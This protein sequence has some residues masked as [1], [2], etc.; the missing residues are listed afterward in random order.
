M[1]L[2]KCETDGKTGWRYGASGTCY[3]YTAGDATSEKA[4]RRLAVKQ[5]LAIGGGKPPADL[6]DRELAE[7]AE[8]TIPEDVEPCLM[9]SS[10]GFRGKGGPQSACHLHDGTPAGIKKAIARALKDV[11]T[12]NPPPKMADALETRDLHDVEI[13]ATGGPYFGQGSPPEGDN[14]DLDYLEQIARN[15]NELADQVQPFVKVGHNSAQRLLRNSGLFTDEQ[16]AAGHLENFRVRGTKLVC[17]IRDV[18]KKLADLV[19]KKAF[20]KRSVELA[21]VVRQSA[22]GGDKERKLVVSALALLGAKAPAVRTLDDIAA[23]Y[24]DDDG[25]LAETAALVYADQ[26]PDESIERTVAFAEGDV[27]WD[28]ENGANDWR[29]D[30]AAAINAGLNPP[31]NSIPNYRYYVCDIDQINKQ[32]LV[33]DYSTNSAWVVPFTIPP[34]TDDG[35]NDGDPVPAPFNDWVMA[36]Q[37]WVQSAPDGPGSGLSDNT[38]KGGILTAMSEHTDT[39]KP[40]WTDEQIA[41]F[42]TGFGIDE[43]DAAKRRE[44]VLAKFEE[45]AKAQTPPPPPEP[46]APQPPEPAAPAVALSE[47]ER[48]YADRL[49]KLEQDRAASEKGRIEA[50]LRTVIAQGKIDPSEQDHW[51]SLMEKD[52]D[53]TIEVLTRLPVRV[54]KLRAFGSDSN[55]SPAEQ[56]EESFYRAYAAATK[57]PV[58]AKEVQQ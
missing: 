14:F 11:G 31:G 4:A 40:E 8:V 45:R 27:I 28:S 3:T 34:D 30:L 43:Q 2:Q 32:A 20:R 53:N 54:D 24:Y 55:G 47:R 48:E 58:P 10:R 37:A 33:Q 25:N 50:N 21:R 19:E 13:L 17:D 57:V 22:D 23:W 46:T 1:P 5:A 36:E 6:S 12:S 51:R 44:A 42:A 35:D 7:Y 38:R 41:S 56:A 18:P 16:P 26:Q 15:N 9:Q 39:Q 49:E 52:Y 29:D